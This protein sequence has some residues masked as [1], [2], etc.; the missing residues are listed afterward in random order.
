M[1]IAKYRKHIFLT[2]AICSV[3]A[4]GI[5]AWLNR[6]N[7][8]SAADAR[9][10]NASN[11]MSDF[12]MTNKSTMSEAQ[13]QAFLVSKNPCNDRNVG[14][15]SSYPHLQY[16]IKNG[17]FVCLAEESFDGESAARIIWQAAQ[18]YNIN[19]Q[20]L[21]VLLEKEQGL[22]TDTWPNHVQYRSAT[23]YGC[24]D[25][26]DCNGKYYGFKNQ[27]RNAANFFRAYQTGNTGW[28]KSVWPGDKYTGAWQPFDYNLQYHPNTGCGTVGTRIENRATASL[29]SYTPYRPNQAALNAQ[30]GHGDG[31]SSY[32]NRNFWMF[33]SDWFGSTQISDT[34]LPHPD[35]TLVD[36]NG[37]VYLVQNKELHH[38]INGSVF[39][40]H[41]YRW[42]DIKPGTTGDR[43][44]PVT[45][46]I[47][48]M[49]PGILYTGDNTGVYTTVKLNGVWTKQLVSYSS[50]VNLGYSWSQ[51][52]TIPASHLPAQTTPVLYSSQDRHPNGTLVSYGGNVYLIDYDTS[53]FVTAAVFESYR[54]NWQDIVPAKAGDISL[55]KGANALLRQ[56][57]LI[58]GGA[59][60]FIV[61]HPSQGSEILLPIGPY[62]CMT[63]ILRYSPEEA[64]NIGPYQLP[65][66]RGS[67]VTC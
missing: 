52:R 19:P 58:Q 10:F 11:I 67:V 60:L 59:D 20:V 46:P 62:E 30:Y 27:V 37:S 44:L 56:G 57:A 40:S 13:I 65:T 9:N 18:D 28:Y 49:S 50:F 8:S 38:I 66:N 23:G 1:Q 26:A 64:I 12:V 31:C 24:P 36:I 42:V 48:F 3:I 53:R 43:N 17:K 35:G 21:I 34:P 32:G 63:K 5:F 51:V 33:F 15:A 45:W 16:N 55:P 41:S 29:Y 2:V 22:V 14:K 61:Q 6:D 7:M 47:D 39:E 25:T 4:I 54:W